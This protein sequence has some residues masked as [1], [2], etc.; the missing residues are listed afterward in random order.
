MAIVI[1]TD[2]GFVNHTLTDYTWS[3]GN[4]HFFKTVERAMYVRDRLNTRWATVIQLAP[5]LH[6]KR[7]GINVWPSEDEEAVYGE[8]SL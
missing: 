2:I 1:K 4:A 7:E 3:L 8:A 6:P 5:R